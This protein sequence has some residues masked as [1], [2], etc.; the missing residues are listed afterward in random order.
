[1]Q[2]SRALVQIVM[3][4]VSVIAMMLMVMVM[5]M[6]IVV[7]VPVIMVIPQPPGAQ[8]VDRQAH[9]GNGNGLLVVD[10]AGAEQALDGLEGHQACHT[11][12]QDCAGVTAQD[13]DLPRAEGKA[14]V[15]R[16]A[17]RTGVGEDRQAQCQRVGAHVPSIGQHGH[18]VVPPASGDLHDHHDQGQ[19]HGPTRVALGERVALVEGVGMAPRSGQG[20]EV[21]DGAGMGCWIPP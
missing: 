4:A 20:I 10:G 9:D 16:E 8:Q 12:Q 18:R 14:T 1:M 19:D 21:H 7:P 5:V 3:G 15:L 6:V 13:F 11:Q 17:A 2:V